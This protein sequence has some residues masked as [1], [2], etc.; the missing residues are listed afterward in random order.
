M[1][2]DILAPSGQPFGVSQE[3]HDEKSTSCF[4]CLEGWVFLGSLGYDGEEVFDAVRCRKC[5]GTGQINC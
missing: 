3:K 5:G 4:Y 2:K 1:D